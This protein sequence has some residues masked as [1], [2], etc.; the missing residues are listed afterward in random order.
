M[1]ALRPGGSIGLRPRHLAAWRR[2]NFSGNDFEQSRRRESP[3]P[4]VPDCQWDALKHLCGCCRT[5]MISAPATPAPI[6]PLPRAS[7]TGASPDPPRS[8]SDRRSEVLRG[9]SGE[10]PA[11]LRPNQREWASGLAI[12]HRS[13]VFRRRRGRPSQ[14]GSPR[15]KRRA[16]GAVQ[17]P[18]VIPAPSQRPPSAAHGCR[19]RNRGSPPTEPNW[20]TTQP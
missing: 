2:V 1:S 6:P 13:L 10:A 5:I 7:L 3:A 16:L 4:Q 20:A 17:R 18:G 15:A 11:R 9:G 14:P 12:G 8:T 19:C